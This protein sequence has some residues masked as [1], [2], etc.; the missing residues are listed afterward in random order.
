[1]GTPNHTLSVVKLSGAYAREATA[2]TLPSEST[3]GPPW[4]AG[5]TDALCW[6]PE[7][8]TS[9]IKP[10]VTAAPA[11]PRPET[12]KIRS[13]TAR[14]GSAGMNGNEGR[15]PFGRIRRARSRWGSQVHTVTFTSVVPWRANTSGRGLWVAARMVVY[16][17]SNSD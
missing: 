5:A 11:E 12:A 16:D 15:L 2:I 6:M 14:G 3:S 10:C 8:E 4:K 9:L 1:M 7:A 13:P 17:A